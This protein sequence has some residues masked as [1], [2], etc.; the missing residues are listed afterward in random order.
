MIIDLQLR[1][2]STNN[3]SKKAPD[4]GLDQQSMGG[5]SQC[6][7]VDGPYNNWN[8]AS[9]NFYADGLNHKSVEGVSQC[10]CLNDEYESFVVDGLI[11]LRSQDVGHLSKKSFVVDSPQFKVK[12]NEKAC[13]SDF[14]LSTQQVQDTCVFELL[15]VVK[16]D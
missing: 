10:T 4:C 3:L 11:S 7:N 9:D 1:L 15:D 5:V 14:C 13:H 2:N 12:D 6:M 8:D 16:D